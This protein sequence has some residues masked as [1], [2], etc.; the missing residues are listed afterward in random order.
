[1]AKNKVLPALIIL[2]ILIIVIVVYRSSKIKQI[3]NTLIEHALVIA[4]PLWNYDTERLSEYLDLM[5]EKYQY[6]ELI[7]VNEDD[8]VFHQK[9][10]PIK[11]RLSGFLSKLGLIPEK[12]FEQKIYFDATYTGKVNVTWYDSSIYFY[13]NATF[14]A[15]LLLLIS[16]LY[17]KVHGAKKNLEDQIVIIED[18]MTELKRQK[19]YV[20]EVFNVVPEGLITVDKDKNNL[21]NNRSFNQ[22]VEH[23]SDLVDMDVSEVKDI[24]LDNLRAQL[25]DQNQGQYSMNLEDYIITIEYNSSAIPQFHKIDRVVSLRDITKL[26]SMERQLA[27]SQKLESVGRL[28][29]GIAHEINTPTQYV[30]ANVQFLEDSHKDVADIMVKVEEAAEKGADNINDLLIESIKEQIEEADWEFLKEEIPESIKQSSEGLR[31][32]SNIVRAM[33]QFSHPSG[34]NP[35]FNDIN[36]AI[37]N[38]VSVASNEWKYVADV[39]LELA[40]DLPNVPCFLDEL[41]QVILA[42]IVNSSHAIE[43][44]YGKDADEKGTITLATRF[45]DENAIITLEDD[46]NGMPN[47][48][49][50]KVFDPFFTTKAV[51]EGT[52]QGLAIAH[53]IIVDRHHGSIS[54][55]SQQ[56][57]GTVFI[58]TLPL[59][60]DEKVG[61]Q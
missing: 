24:F 43:A 58:I 6:K 4:E 8:T 22:I 48:V 27:Q 28:A 40:E 30:L 11:G 46:G 50:E 44:K 3:D 18:Q 39:Q 9:V 16:N 52:G 26:T 35:E 32:I 2:C 7:I 13:A 33:K 36:D 55:Q 47:N 41:N 25:H 15:F 17:T 57:E 59:S 20:E 37:K 5:A 34:E 60:L 10:Y 56:G 1:M 53:N 21:G 31:R 29:A 19:E 12:K 38:T 49:A 51:N 14:V 61:I 54:V 23:W 45:T 42:M